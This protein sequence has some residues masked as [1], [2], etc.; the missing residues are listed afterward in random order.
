MRYYDHIRL[1]A[2]KAIAIALTLAFAA[3]YF[4]SPAGGRAE[5]YAGESKVN[6]APAETAT[7][8]ITSHPSDVIV[9][10]GNRA[11]FSV[12][13]TGSELKYQWYCRKQGN[14]KW[15]V[16]SG[17]TT[18]SITDTADSTWDMMKVYCRVTDASGSTVSSNSAVVRLAKPIVL[19]KQPKNITVKPGEKMAFSVSAQGSGS[20]HYQWFFRKADMNQGTAWSGNTSPSLSAIADET[21]NLMRVWCVI[22]DEAGGTAL[23]ETAVVTVRQPLSIQT[24]PEGVMVKAGQVPEIFLSAKGT[25]EITY[26]WY[27]KKAGAN[28]WSVWTSQTSPMISAQADSSWNM[29]EVYCKLTDASGA[30]LVSDTAI[31]RISQPLSVTVQPVSTNVLSGTS[32]KTS[33]TARGTGK[34]SY[35]W[36]RRMPDTKSWERWYGQTGSVLSARAELSMNGMQVYCRVSDESGA[37]VN[38]R[39]A[40]IIVTPAVKIITQPAQVTVHSGETA[41][42]SITAS[43]S[44][45]RYQWYRKKAGESDWTLWQEGTEP[46]VTEEA[47]CTWHA[48]QVYCRVTDENGEAV[49]SSVTFAMITKKSDQIYINRTFTVKSN[50]TTVYSGPGTN[51]SSVGTVKAGARY[52]A[53]EWDC[54]SGDATW[55]R[56][57]LNGKS[58][59]IA[60][61]KTSVYRNECVTIPSRSFK[62]GGVPIIYLSPSRQTKNEYAAGSTTEGE[63]MYRVGN[64]L[65]K[66]LEEEYLCV[67]Y[68]PPVSMKINF[69]CRP[70]DA[71]NKDADVYLAIHS[72]AHSS[73]KMYGAVGYY[74]PGCEQSR[75]LGEN[76][77][78][79]MGKISPF[80]PTVGSKTVDGMKGFEN[81]GYAEVRDPAYYG[82]ISLLAEVEYHDNADSARWIIDNPKNI[83]RALANALEK[84]IDLQKK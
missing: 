74:F 76:M 63:Q 66:I 28:D 9:K 32:L 20:L 8:A 22:T 7:L 18:A 36:F 21:C 11:S 19:Q 5:V 73:K 62:E 64:E 68:M 53:L 37:S 49:D 78:N 82:M 67:V 25:G 33:V 52:L 41:S 65:K 42:F 81:V 13:A 84:T 72:N 31:V 75:L 54:D 24:Q 50:G 29:M 70:T 60:R 58:A 61:S 51:Y 39:S 35:Q 56:F 30:Q 44:G 43:G 2:K 17:H 55:Y 10:E 3:G 27:Y 40:R 34:C 77:A 16:W 47:D 23:S 46:K 69:N 80:M 6:A 4:I 48:M 71:Y 45:L 15:Q 1:S 59:W 57:N 83:A 12:E 38:S 79:E 26:Q 14:R